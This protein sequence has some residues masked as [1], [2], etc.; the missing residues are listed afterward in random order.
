MTSRP[1]PY[2]RA[3]RPR[4]LPVG[5]LTLVWVLLWGDWSWGVV[6]SG[7]GIAL[8]VITVLPLPS[9]SLGGAPSPWWTLH[10]LARFGVDLVRGSLLVAWQAVRPAPV[11]VSSVIG[12]R[13]RSE[14]EL[15]MVLLME[16]ISL[17]PGTLGLELVPEERMLYLHMLDAPDEAAVERERAVV[18]ATERRLVRAMGSATRFGPSDDEIPIDPTEA[19]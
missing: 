15:V 16:T 1:S 18:L 11:P 19:P 3:I 12:I 4:L 9:V 6:L 2:T 10:Y 14:S 8:V 5:W 7:A 17:T 13:L